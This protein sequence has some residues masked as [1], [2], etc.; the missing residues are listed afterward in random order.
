MDAPVR[1]A[2]V[3]LPRLD[4]AQ[5]GLCNH[6][7]TRAQCSVVRIDECT[8]EWRWID[9]DASLAPVIELV[10]ADGP[11]ECLLAIRDDSRA[12][13]DA[14]IQLEAFDGEALVLAATLRHA[15]VVAH[16]SA[17]SGRRWQCVDV[18]RP[19]DQV[20]YRGPE[21]LR[22]A[23]VLRDTGPGIAGDDT[24]ARTTGHLRLH[25][26]EAHR[27]RSV[28]G[29]P[30]PPAPIL[31]ALGFALDIA[32]HAAPALSRAEL[33]SI[34]PGGAV[35]LG[36]SGAQGIACALTLPGRAHHARATL[37]GS[38]L[39]LCGPL[40][41]GAAPP[42]IQTRSDTMTSPAHGEDQMRLAIESADDT[43]P[44][45]DATG[46]LDAVPVTVEFHLGQLTLP[47]AE[48]EV[49]FAEGRI[50]ELGEPL[51]SQS[52]TLRAGG[53]ELARGELLQVGD[54]VAVR[55]TRVATRGSV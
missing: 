41:A 25:R 39:V 5:V 1:H 23:F 31:R 30:A 53:V 18:L 12:G 19:D 55:I 2:A 51:G 3:L 38:R 27:W 26:D 44:L 47:L 40:R 8:R 13:I 33:R 14:S 28:F 48:L 34:R 49:E 45:R 4:Q 42:P 10:L 21:F 50:F 43:R 7:L 9:A 36:R 11:S 16:L 17:L 54:V 6:L 46:L 20:Q 15:A 37:Q 32:L 24:P 22:C 52:V 29:R 35:L